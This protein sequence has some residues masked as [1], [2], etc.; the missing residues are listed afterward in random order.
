MYYNASA[1]TTTTDGRGAHLTWP[2]DERLA[3]SVTMRAED[4]HRG[5]KEHGNE[6]LR[7]V[8]RLDDGARECELDER[9]IAEAKQLGID[10]R[11]EQ[12]LYNYY[13]KASSMPALAPDAPRRSSVD[14]KA[15]FA[16]SMM[17]TGSS[18]QVHGSGNARSSRASLSFRDYDNFLSRGRAEGRKSMSFSPP[19][20]PSASASTFSLPLSEPEASAKKQYRLL[21]GLS[22]LKI[23]R[24]DSATSLKG[25]PHCPRDP[26][27]QRRAVHKLPCG[28]RLCTPA[29]RDTIR[30]ATS[31]ETGAIPS[32]CGI[33]VPSSLI[34]H[35]MTQQE[36][37]AF[38]DRYEQWSQPNESAARLM[39]SEADPTGTVHRPGALCTSSRTVS[40]ESKVDSVAPP[41]TRNR[42]GS[43]GNSPEVKRLYKEQAE[44]RHRFNTWIEAKRAQMREQHDG[45][46]TEMRARFDA[47]V[48]N[49]EEKHA[50]LMS[51]AEDKQ[52][53]AEAE[54][55]VI[56]AQEER[57]SATALK[58][59]E[60]FCAGMYMSTG[61]PHGRPITEQDY[62]E[63]QNARTRT[64]NLA[65]RHQGAINVLR[66]E[67]SRRLRLREQRQDKEL[68]ELSRGQRREEL[69]LERA[70]TD[71]GRAFEEFVE[72]RR[73]GL[74][75]RWEL[76]EKIVRK[77]VEMGQGGHG[78][79]G[80]GYYDDGYDV[81]ELLQ[82]VPGALAMLEGR[83]EGP[84]RW[85]SGTE[86]S[87]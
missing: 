59:M 51:E 38:L 68:L 81:D 6:Y 13:E 37:N 12:T 61:R 7:D 72:W 10:T 74:R 70:C 75:R 87:R 17:S 25:C 35:A 14:S 60:A 62:T 3:C 5:E 1:C 66:G 53:H 36:Q 52:V 40:D 11:T 29:L 21:R 57:D 20:T 41:E 18:M 47:S 85:S 27:S 9:L 79:G 55:R 54:M 64:Q 82:S 77:K 44:L 42:A 26:L 67:Q 65:G 31:K 4:L 69:D 30:A 2:I 80:G 86:L 49:L 8:L 46:R 22:I 34:E 76:Q 23:H 39:Q 24:V 83:I 73:A 19:R 84:Y 71:E 78:F 43:Q 15:S 32:C 45:W 50:Q 63:L 58:H 16:T 28:H 33:P 48:E 56:H